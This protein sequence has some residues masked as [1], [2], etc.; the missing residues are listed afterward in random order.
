MARMP[1]PRAGSRSEHPPRADRG[2]DRPIRVT[3]P[4]GLAAAERALLEVAGDPEQA[5]SDALLLLAGR[6][7]DAETASVA[8]RALG[9][10]ER[11]TGRLKDARRNLLKA[12]GIAEAGGLGTRVTEARM[13]LAAVLLKQGSPEAALI[14]LDR[15]GDEPSGGL[16]GQLLQ[17]RALVLLRLGRFEEALA[18]TRS[19]LPLVRRSGD[20]LTEARLFSNRGVLNGFRGDLVLAERDLDK[21]LVIYRALGSQFAGA[22]V[23]HNLGYVAA[24]RGDVPEALKRYDA[25]AHRFAA[26]HLPAPI[27]HADRAELLLSVRLLPEARREIDICV[28]ALEARRV[29]IDLAEARVLLGQIALAEGDLAAAAAAARLARR[30]LVR[31]SRTRW[32][33]LARFVAA[34]ASWASSPNPLRVA[35]DAAALAT[36]L[37]SEDWVLPGLECRII[38]A[39]AALR[40]G[41]LEAAKSITRGKRR[42]S[43]T[44]PA[45]QLVREWHLEAL[46]RVA[47]G[48]RIGA[49]SAIRAGLGVAEEHR[50][51]LGATELRV[52]TATTVAELARLGLELAFSSQRAV[53]VLEWSE[54]WRA[55]ALRAPRA[56]PPRDQ[57][58]ADLLSGLRETVARLE[59][60]SLSGG[61]VHQ[62]VGRQR[63]LEAEIRQRSRLSHGELVAGEAL[64]SP[65]ELRAALGDRALVEFVDHEERLYAVVGTAKGFALHEL[66]DSAESASARASLQ[67]SLGRLALR[68]SP[69]ASLNAAAQLLERALRR[70]E[71]LLMAPIASSVDGRELVVVPTGE[72]HALPWALLPSLRGRT[73][74]VAPSAALWFHRRLP[75]GEQPS[76]A[77]T[78]ALRRGPAR[79]GPEAGGGPRREQG[80]GV[81]LVAGP[82]VA[83]GDEEV[84]RLFSSHYQGAEVL[85]GSAA[86]TRDVAQS[87]EGRWL[88]HVAAHG[89]F[90]ADNAQFSSL[91][92]ADGPLTVYDIERIVSPPA[93]MV[94][95]S[96]D[97]GRSEVHPGNELMGTSAALLSLGTRAIVSSVAPVPDEGVMPVMVALH[98]GL[99]AGHGLAGALAAA[100]RAALADLVDARD[101]AAGDE[102]AR[103]ALAGGAFVCLGAG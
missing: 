92:L 100:Q 6:D 95:S 72:L 75:A 47:D 29:P 101:L 71:E 59:R 2:S 37:E 21:A 90:R 24:L 99:A 16:R 93:W 44:S 38:G 88:A 20:R 86:T 52:R 91:E 94:L 41:S 7:V 32:A 67:F 11:E 48:N 39:R 3:G 43:P 77:G 68:K 5:R 66:C 63:R 17:Q 36:V 103:T 42:R 62:L 9:L 78:P 74:A 45:S 102:A 49:R 76:P 14:E 25:A 73:T 12:A 57:H 97:A 33:A 19:A 10:A 61:D 54:R 98:G 4:S 27:L 81:V 1:S 34:Q 51:T 26:L 31:Q 28:R 18:A 35:R 56:T 46:S 53:E 50:A 69:Q 82:G 85:R 80:R 13:S 55:G 79:V 60:A 23:L 64:P 8:L 96:C 40:G 89:T 84:R 58:L 87:F 83:Q 65:G 30:Q 15:L 22:Q 70:L